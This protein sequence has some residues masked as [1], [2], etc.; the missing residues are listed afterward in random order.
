VIMVEAHV[1]D[2]WTR[3]S[4]RPGAPYAIA[5]F[6]AGLG[7]P[8]FLFLAGAALPMAAS[9]RASSV[10]HRRAAAAA[11][12]RG[13]Q[14]FA[15]A[16]LFRLQ[17]QLIGW[18]PLVN[19]LKVDILNVMGLALVMAGTIWGLSTSRPRRI[20]LFAA[21]CV[22]FAMSTPLIR[23]ATWLAALP[24]PI[25]WYF[26][27]S[28]G[29]TSFVLFPWAAFLFAGAIVGETVDALGSRTDA[30][31]QSWFACAA[32]AIVV[33]AYWASLQPSIYPV[34]NF[35]LS[36]PTFFFIRLG[37]SLALVPLAWVLEKT[38]PRLGFLETF[39]RSSLFVYWIH[40]EMVY[41]VIAKPLEHLL[42]LEASLLGMVALCALLLAIV[43]WKNRA[44]AQYELPGPFRIL[45]PVLR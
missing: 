17:A 29:H 4:D 7:A 2:A 36:S 10:G 15:L 35:W 39:G 9:R 22:G 12:L 14:V 21:A 33:A 18:G 31:L 13:W 6:I 24:D 19:F 11:G 16:F 27:P 23:E 44:L 3:D 20:L 41:G 42:A 37:L 34:S 1:I 25:E 40:V 32:I 26:R 28:E 43:R 5:V 38:A 45:A 8:L 30:W